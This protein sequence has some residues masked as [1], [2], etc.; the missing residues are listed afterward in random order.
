LL[1]FYFVLSPSILVYPPPLLLQPAPHPSLL[2]DSTGRAELP[3]ETNPFR[4]KV[5]VPQTPAVPVR[6]VFGFTHFPPIS[7]DYKIREN[8]IFKFF[9]H[10]PLTFYLERHLVWLSFPSVAIVRARVST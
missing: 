7:I 4:R 5:A 9:S 6:V 1:S 8:Q 3:T 2:D 10:S